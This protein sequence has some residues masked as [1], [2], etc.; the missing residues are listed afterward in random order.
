[1]HYIIVSETCAEVPLQVSLDNDCRRLFELLAR[2]NNPLFAQIPDEANIE[3]H[4]KLGMD[5]NGDHSL[6][7]QVVFESTP[8][9]NYQAVLL[10]ATVYWH[11]N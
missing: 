7:Q 1:M 4:H 3:F 5:G 11:W 8:L 9:S 6:Y 2:N 10:T